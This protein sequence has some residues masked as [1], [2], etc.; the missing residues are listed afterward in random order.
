MYREREIEREAGWA[1]ARDQG[2]ERYID[3]WIK[4]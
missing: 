4:R 1:E 2:R 3:G